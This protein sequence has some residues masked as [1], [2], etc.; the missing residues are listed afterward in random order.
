MNP[1]RRRVRR[2]IRAGGMWCGGF[3]FVQSAIYR[4]LY[5][6]ETSYRANNGLETYNFDTNACTA[7]VNFGNGIH[8]GER[9]QISTRP[10]RFEFC[11][12]MQMQ[13]TPKKLEPETCAQ[14]SCTRK[15]HEYLM[16][17]LIIFITVSCTSIDIVSIGLRCSRL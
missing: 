12:P 9:E 16:Q 8:T 11:M 4:P 1:P 15:L 5:R 13:H 7:T 17:V 3:R 14:E 6:S 2:E 10:V